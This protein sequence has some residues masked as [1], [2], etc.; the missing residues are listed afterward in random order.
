MTGSFFMDLFDT[1]A[2]FDNTMKHI[3]SKWIRREMSNAE[4]APGRYLG[5]ES[6]RGGN[7]ICAFLSS[8]DLRE[9]LPI[10]CFF[11]FLCDLSIR[12]LFTCM[13]IAIPSER[14]AKLWT[15]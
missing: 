8:I 5:P 13:H 4:T 1:F 3:K 9:P 7:N 2:V 14:S 15:R 12:G 6:R 11:G 10:S